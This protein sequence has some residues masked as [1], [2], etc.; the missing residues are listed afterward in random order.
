MYAKARAER[1]AMIRSDSI[2][3]AALGFGLLLL[4]GVG[5]AFLYM[6]GIVRS[7]LVLNAAASVYGLWFF[8]KGLF[9]F[10][11]A[12]TKNGSLANDD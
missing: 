9:Y 11:F 8:S 7:L 12:H 3:K 5:G 4:T 10:F 6:G 1:M 2:K